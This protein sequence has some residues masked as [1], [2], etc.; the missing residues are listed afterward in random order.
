MRSQSTTLYHLR[1]NILSAVLMNTAQER[2]TEEKGRKRL[3]WPTWDLAVT[4]RL[5]F[6]IYSSS[7]HSAG[8]N[9]F[10]C[11]F[12][13]HCHY[14]ATAW[15]SPPGAVRTVRCITWSYSQPY[16]ALQELRM[17]CSFPSMQDQSLGNLHQSHRMHCRESAA[18]QHSP[19]RAQA[20]GTEQMISIQS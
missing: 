7:L 14:R 12:E 4:Q 10:T 1:C 19:G 3:L 6:F 9:W 18:T 5:C 11:S 13:H 15:T 2:R 17:L 16:A 20:G 8:L